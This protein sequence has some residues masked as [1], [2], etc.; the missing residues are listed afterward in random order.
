M[1]PL[2]AQGDLLTHL[3][4]MNAFATEFTERLFLK[5]TDFTE[6]TEKRGFFKW[7]FP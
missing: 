6:C 2:I 1:I 7:F 3:T 5:Y 4:Q